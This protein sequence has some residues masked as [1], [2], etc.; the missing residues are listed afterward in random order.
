MVRTSP[1]V[2]MLIMLRHDCH[3]QTEVT[4]SMVAAHVIHWGRSCHSLGPLL[5]FTGAA[6]VVHWGRSCHSQARSTPSHC[7]T[8]TVTSRAWTVMLK[9]QRYQDTTRI[10]RIFTEMPTVLWLC[11]S[12]CSRLHCLLLN[13]GILL[14]PNCM[15]YNAVWT[16]QCV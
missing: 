7:R 13:V 8:S 3:E 5:S 4:H 16:S 12:T 1:D 9:Y 11:T 6:P 15:Q 14:K 10:F 2:V